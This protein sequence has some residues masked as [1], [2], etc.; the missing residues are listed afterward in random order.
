[1][2]AKDFIVAIELGSSKLRGIAGKKNNDGSISVFATASEDSS[3][4]IKKGIVYNIEKTVQ[5]I[6]NVVNKLKASLDKEIS[7]VYVGVGGQSILGVRN[8]IVRNLPKDTIITQ[9]MVNEIMDNNSNKKYDD[10]E[11]IDVVIQEYKVGNDLQDEPAGIQTDQVTGNF[12]NIL[13]R[14]SF[15][16]KLTDCFKRAGIKIAEMGIA[17]LALADILLDESSKRSGCMLVDLGADTTTMLVYHKNILRHIAVIPLGSSNITKDLISL[18]HIDDFAKA[19]SMKKQYGNAYYEPT[20]ESEEYRIDAQHTIA[21]EK[22][23]QVV[24]SRIKEIVEN[25]WQQI[26]SEYRTKLNG[27]IVLTGGGANLKDIEKAFLKKSETMKISIAKFIPEKV[28]IIGKNVHL[29]EDCTMN[30][31]LGM[32]KKGEINCNGGERNNGL[33]NNDGTPNETAQAGAAAKQPQQA[34][35]AYGAGNT[36]G[37][38]TPEEIA[39]NAEE[40]RKRDKEEWENAKQ[41]NTVEA[42]QSYLEKF[43]SGIFTSEAKENMEELSK[44]PK[45]KGGWWSK[46]SKLGKDIFTEPEE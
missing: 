21:S 3:S 24:E 42:Y 8:E 39:A 9:Q 25:V 37:I 13:W 4:Y 41:D 34:G 40:Q 32:L 16:N 46:L 20:D 28:N 30:T 7:Q 1:M 38:K 22:F 2:P 23:Q 31:L 6:T 44:K 18:N 45:Q 43:P 26:P 29:P 5:G 36:T 35:P 10:K 12:L 11:I 15:Y 33:F 17:P 27:G 19:E 14:E